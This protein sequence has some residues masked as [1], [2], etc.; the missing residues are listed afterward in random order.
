MPLYNY[1][2]HACGYSVEHFA[3]VAERNVRENE[4]CEKCSAMEVKIALGATLW[5]DPFVLGKIKPKADFM[6]RIG[7]IKKRNKG[8]TIDV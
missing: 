5:I 4:P 1:L 6:E 3:S 2:C 8:N 7:Q